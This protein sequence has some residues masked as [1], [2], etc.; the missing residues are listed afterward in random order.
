MTRRRRSL[1]LLLAAPLA[2]AVS[3]QLSACAE[4]DAE[5]TG[6]A[7]GADVRIP[8]PIPLTAPEDTPLALDFA[9]ATTGGAVAK[10]G[11]NPDLLLA[12]EWSAKLVTAPSH[13][14]VAV[15][16]LVVRYVPEPDYFG[17]DTGAVEVRIHDDAARSDLVFDALVQIT[18][19]PVNDAPTLAG[20][21]ISP[22]APTAA[23][24]L[25]ANAVDL[26][27]IDS[28]A[29]TVTVR[30]QWLVNGAP[31]AGATTPTLGAGFAAGDSVAVVGTPFD[32]Q[33]PGLPV[34]SPAVTIAH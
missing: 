25:T 4:D 10:L 32:G 8:F 24:T 15:D 18:L 14:T 6:F 20:V 12:A 16:G 2:L 17:P 26:A 5:T 1:S 27:D 9:K 7:R 29:T 22:A 21:M 13:G 33:L 23:D 34:T 19:L 3:L 28:P 31:A 11:L 30:W